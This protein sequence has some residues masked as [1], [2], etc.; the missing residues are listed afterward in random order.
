[1][2][3]REKYD[4]GG[5][6]TLLSAAARVSRCCMTSAGKGSKRKWFVHYGV[7]VQEPE[8]ACADPVRVLTDPD[9][10]RGAR[11]HGTIW[12]ADTD[13]VVSAE[14]PIAVSVGYSHISIRK[15]DST[16]TS[17]TKAAIGISQN[18]NGT[19][20]CQFWLLYNHAVVQ[21]NHFHLLPFPVNLTGTCV[22]RPSPY[23]AY[24]K[25][26]PFPF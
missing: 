18:P 8:V 14:L 26:M 3:P 25:P 1:M 23:D 16:M 17:R 13:V 6:T 11:S 5:V 15:P 21:A 4:D 20:T 22:P 19:G 2:I 7:V 10:C 24:T 9:C 12:L